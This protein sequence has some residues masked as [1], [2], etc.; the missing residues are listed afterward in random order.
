M[1]AR[2][3]ITKTAS[4]KSLSVHPDV[5][6]VLEQK[7]KGFFVIRLKIPFGQVNSDQLPRIARISK[8]YGRGELYFTTRQG[9]EIPWVESANLEKA[10]EA[11]T[12]I[13]LT[14]GASS[15][16]LRVV[17]ACPGNSVCKHGQ[18]NSQ[19]FAKDIDDRF[20]GT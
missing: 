19:G 7:Q 1:E 20:F 13:G 18:K 17:T 8:K 16:R 11:I 3:A 4:S 15:P 6:G 10:K 2:K 5:G 14:L 9:V 12:A